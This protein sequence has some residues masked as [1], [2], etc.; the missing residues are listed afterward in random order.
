MKSEYVG[1]SAGER[2]FGGKNILHGQLDLI[3]LLKSFKIYKLLR[4]EE[5]LLKVGLK[6]KIGEVLELIDKFEKKLPKTSYSADED[7]KDNAKK[8]KRDMGLQAE[9]EEIHEKLEKLRRLT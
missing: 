3:D 2:E 8:R 6:S 5:L 4:Q 1:L 7:K 9:V